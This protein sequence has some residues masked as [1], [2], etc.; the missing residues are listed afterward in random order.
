MRKLKGKSNFSGE[1]LKIKRLN[2]KLN[3]TEMARELQL[4]GLNMSI[5]D[6][7]RIE[8]SR[9]LLKDFE[10]I[11]F[12]MVLDI[13]LNELKLYYRNFIYDEK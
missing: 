10:L 6:I 8:T 5:D 11:A 3:R 9:V 1:Y 13:D 2:K 7:Y 4:L 12:A